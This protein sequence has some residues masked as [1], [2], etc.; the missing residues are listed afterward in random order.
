MDEREFINKEMGKTQ[1]VQEGMYY[2]F[3]PAKLPLKYV[4]SSKVLQQL[5]KTAL[6]LGGLK[7]LSKD[8]SRQE[9]LLL[10]HP[11][12]MKEA[13][14]SS[15]MEGTRSTITE[16]YKEEKIKEEN[17][18]K[19][20]DNEEIR[21]YRNALEYALREE[22]GIINEK[23]LK[24]IHKILLTGV[25]GENKFP[26]EYKSKQNAVGKREDTFDSARFVPA[27]PEETPKLMENL[28]EFINSSDYEPL[29]KIAMAHYQFEAT[30]PFRDGNGR[31]GRLLIMLQLCRE[32]ILS[33][34]L[35]YISEY[36]NRNRDT[37]TDLLFE[38]SAKGN[39][40]EWFFFF[41]KSLEYQAS[42]SLILLTKLQNYKKELQEKMHKISQSPNI[43]LLVESLFKQPIFSIKDVENSLKITQP[44]AWNLLK[45][46]KELDLIKEFA[47][48]KNKKIYIAHKIIG[49]VEGKS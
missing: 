12:L 28:V 33:H 48:I 3:E 23:M 14:L 39:I 29:Y 8:F 40:E 9:I 47:T 43:H 13:Q 25:R 7:T 45:K 46:L 24:Q 10:Q 44:A 32:E 1:W 22:D 38:V 30:H 26:G 11:F 4:P 18:E 5:T 15:E 49:I 2:R 6:A 41:L 20:L 34:P 17:T 37:Y 31:I 16:I 21:N 35:L 42:Q 27:S 36:F 19:R